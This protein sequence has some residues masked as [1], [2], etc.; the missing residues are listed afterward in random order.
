MEYPLTR[1]ENR[2]ICNSYSSEP[3][4]LTVVFDAVSLD[5]IALIADRKLTNTI[6]GKDDVGI[7]IQGIWNIF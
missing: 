4:S 5:G 6:G 2:N 3:Y 7:K 1:N